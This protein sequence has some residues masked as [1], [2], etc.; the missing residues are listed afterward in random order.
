MAHFILHLL[1]ILNGVTHE[2]K[3]GNCL[4]EISLGEDTEHHQTHTIS[5]PLSIAYFNETDSHVGVL[6][7]VEENNTKTCIS[8]MNPMPIF[9][10]Y[11]FYETA[12]AII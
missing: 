9:M 5:Q 3:S 12:S 1:L 6:E 8:L 11:G 4:V 10:G 7:I 2:N